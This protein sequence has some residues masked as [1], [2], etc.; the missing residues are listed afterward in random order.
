MN[1][2]HIARSRNAYG[3]KR[4]LAPLELT[5]V[6]T[7]KTDEYMLPSKKNIDHLPLVL[8]LHSIFEFELDS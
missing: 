4:F 2:C 7:N 8:S 6:A 1:P 3:L 5:V